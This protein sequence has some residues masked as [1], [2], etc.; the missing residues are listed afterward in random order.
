MAYAFDTTAGT[1]VYAIAVGATVAGD[2]LW[3][4]TGTVGTS[5][6]GPGYQGAFNPPQTA[7]GNNPSD[8]VNQWAQLDSGGTSTWR[9]MGPQQAIS[10]DPAGS[11]WY[12]VPALFV[13]V[14]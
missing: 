12:K 1:N 5:D 10:Y 2:K 13:R 9:N 6:L 14:S 4:H 11:N 8:D 3:Y 7:S